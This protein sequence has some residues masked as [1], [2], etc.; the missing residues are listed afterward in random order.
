MFNYSWRNKKQ[1]K[2][3]R[4]TDI[5]INLNIFTNW[6]VISFF[7]CNFFVHSSIIGYLWR[8]LKPISIPEINKRKK[9]FRKIKIKYIWYWK[10]IYYVYTNLNISCTKVHVFVFVFSFYLLRSR[11][12]ENV[13]EPEG[14]VACAGDD[15]LSVGAHCQVENPVRVAGQLRYL[16]ETR[17]LPDKN[18]RKILF[19]VLII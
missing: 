12:W 10:L 16:H 17:V 13:P 3:I 14:L 9:S 4:K 11:F 1:Q 6:K 18:L 8:D 2:Q 15:G 7:N 5:K 19:R